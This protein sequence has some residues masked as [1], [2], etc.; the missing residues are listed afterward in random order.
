[1]YSEKVLIDWTEYQRLKSY[2]KK[3]ISL[4]KQ[5]ER[6][7]QKVSEQSG[8]GSE[9]ELE[10]N[11]LIQE[12]ENDNVPKPQT[13]LEPITAPKRI[14]DASLPSTS[15]ESNEGTPEISAPKKRKKNAEKLP[16]KWYFIGVPKYKH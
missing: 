7:Q 8:Q 2:E 6:D 15:K 10:R 13:I 16:E 5:V 1:M 12:N 14:E 11:I 9:Q 3:Y 4:K